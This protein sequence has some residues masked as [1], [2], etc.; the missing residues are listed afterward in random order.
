[1]KLT[2][3][4]TNIKRKLYLHKSDNVSF[5]HKNNNLENNIVSVN[6]DIY[7]QD[8]IGF[9]GAFTES[10]CYSLNTVNKT[11]YNKILD[12][13]F[14]KDGLNYNLCRLPIGSS[15]FSL[16]SYSYSYK[17]DLSDFSI[18]RDMKY[19]IPTIKEAQKRNTDIE[20]LASPWS[21]PSFM[22]STNN[23]YN[24][25]KLLKQYYETWA[26]YLVKYIE[27]YLS[28]NIKI[29]Y[30]T[31]Q[32]EPNASQ[33]WESCTYTAEEEANLLKN[34]LVPIFR[35]N[36]ID[37]KFLIWDHNKD[38]ILNRTIDTLVTNGAL[39]YASGIAFHWYTGSHFEN[40]R[41]IKKLFPNKLLIHT[42]GC[43][44]Y[45]NFKASDELF[46]AEMYA[47]EII[48]DLN[49]ETNGFIDWNMVLEYNGGPNHKHNYCNSPI[50]INK[51]HDNYIKT[52]SFYYIGHFSKYIKPGA[53]RIHFSTFSDNIQITSF[54]NLDN[55]V[56]IILLNK[57]NFNIE[58]NLCYKN[59]TFHDNLDSHAIVTFIISE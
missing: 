48:G 2:K 4:E 37:M 41:E 9:G 16:N 44:G 52:P 32:N 39:D 17:K 40:L 21:P 10:T 46:N 35:K 6:P 28:N 24:G 22:K 13:Y 50:M 55:S 30:I 33:L 38:D 34:Y 45:S 58:Y 14:S 59:Y 27:N 20:F 54:K 57:N 8:L 53:K 1:M 25:G 36:K 3:I 7:F 31:I 12:E 5:S 26:N 11:L 51:K 49:N 42:E 18:K 23:L 19:I 43:T 29:K 56:I 47:S 15:D